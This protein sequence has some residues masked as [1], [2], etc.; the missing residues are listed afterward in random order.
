MEAF[1]ISSKSEI[2]CHMR[3]MAPQAEARVR[4]VLCALEHTPL[5]PHMKWQPNY[6]CHPLHICSAT[7]T[8]T[9][10]YSFALPEKITFL[11]PTALQAVS[12]INAL[13]APLPLLSLFPVCPAPPNTIHT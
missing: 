9:E 5:L 7:L 6:Q 12:C 11:P 13:V 8:Q 2:H 4:N 3:T 1:H 10:N